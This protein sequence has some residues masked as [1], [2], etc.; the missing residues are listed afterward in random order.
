MFRR[1]LSIAL[2]L[3]AAAAVLEGMLAVWVLG[4]AE[5]HVQRGRVASDLH[6]GYVELSAAK[7]RL[8]TWVA[9]VQFGP[10]ADLAQ[11][12]NL[13]SQMRATLQRLQALSER[14]VAL[15]DSARPVWNTCT[16]KIVWRCWSAICSD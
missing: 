14:A 9:Q 6:V 16:G 4:V 3:L 12:D 1:R 15:D 13:Q 11:R 7:Q 5:R 10:G 2:L 8:R